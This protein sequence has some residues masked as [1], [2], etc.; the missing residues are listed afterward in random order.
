[1][2]LAWAFLRAGEAAVWK[3]NEL[4]KLFTFI[5]EIPN[6][7]IRNELHMALRLCVDG[8]RIAAFCVYSLSLWLKWSIAPIS[9]CDVVICSLLT[10]KELE[11]IEW[12]RQGGYL[13]YESTCR[14]S[15]K[16]SFR[17]PFLF[18]QITLPR[19]ILFGVDKFKQCRWFV[20]RNQSW[21]ELQQSVFL[22]QR[23]EN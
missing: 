6:D 13:A 3:P 10:G 20:L 15:L 23:Q 14:C 11:Y 2:P 21:R 12:S 8:R 19:S 18:F 16:A 22:L 4:N 17:P 7:R 1:M 5:P 9:L